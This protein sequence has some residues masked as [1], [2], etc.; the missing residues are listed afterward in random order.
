MTV[1]WLQILTLALT[2][3][4]IAGVTNQLLTLLREVRT[5]KFQSRQQ[6]AE[7]AHQKAT[8]ES[9]RQHAARLRNET[10]HSDARGTLLD[11]AVDVKHWAMQVFIDNWSHEV[12]YYGNTY[13]RA[14]TTD[15]VDV[16][17]K[18]Q[19]IEDAHPTRIVRRMAESLRGSIDSV[20]NVPVPKGNGEYFDLTPSCDQSRDWIVKSEALVEEMHDGGLDMEERSRSFPHLVALS[21]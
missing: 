9:E 18:L 4:V 19:R 16:L 13:P 1:T 14:S 2:S 6:D 12:D 11:P 3:G 7:R 10:A 8:Q 20:Y 17:A 5:R 15:P 21:D